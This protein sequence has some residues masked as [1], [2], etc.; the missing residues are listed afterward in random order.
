MSQSAALYNFGDDMGCLLLTQVCVYFSEWGIV[1]EIRLWHCHYHPA[2]A[3]GQWN[4]R[5]ILHFT[6]ILSVNSTPSRG[7]F[8]HRSNDKGGRRIPWKFYLHPFYQKYVLRRQNTFVGFFWT[9]FESQWDKGPIRQLK[10]DTV[11]NMRDKVWGLI[12]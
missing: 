4:I 11:S 3:P 10:L 6:L 5:G 9:H 1:Q 8:L 2:I 12:W 7:H